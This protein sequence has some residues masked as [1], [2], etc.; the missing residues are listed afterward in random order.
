MTSIWNGGDFT[1]LC[2]SYRRMSSTRNVVMMFGFKGLVSLLMSLPLLSI[3]RALC[4]LCSYSLFMTSRSEH[5]YCALWYF[6]N[7][8][9]SIKHSN[10]MIAVKQNQFSFTVQSAECDWQ[11]VPA[12]LVKMTQ[13][14]RVELLLRASWLTGCKPV[15][16]KR[17]EQLFRLEW[18]ICIGL[19]CL[20]QT[21]S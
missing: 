5:L 19:D 9:R 1:L 8:S 10:K 2:C 3:S 11:V 17:S 12:L 6:S 14:C 7:K 20:S 13:S 18:L 15:W 21:P 4:M 16:L